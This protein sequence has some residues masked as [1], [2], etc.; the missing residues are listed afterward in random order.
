MG[1]LVRQIASDAKSVVQPP[2]AQSQRNV[3]ILAAAGIE[4]S[5]ALDGRAPERA[6]CSRDASHLVRQIGRL[7]ALRDADQVL[8]SLETGYQACIEITNDDVSCHGP[9]LRVVEWLKQMQERM[10]IEDDAIAIDIDDDVAR[11]PG[12]AQIARGGLA[13]SQLSAVR[14][15]DEPLFLKLAQLRRHLV[16]RSVADDDDLVR[17]SALF[18]EGAH[19]AF[20]RLRLVVADDHR[21]NVADV[22]IAWP[23][24]GRAKADR[25][26]GEKSQGVARKLEDNDEPEQFEKARMALR[27]QI[28]YAI[29]RRAATS[30][31]VLRAEG[32]KLSAEIDAHGALGALA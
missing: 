16:R 22:D 6:E 1:T 4:S 9:D 27:C 24:P 19:T 2:A 11:R 31:K 15:C 5:H 32:L 29:G 17:R 7:L 13:G 8:D 20:D 3:E 18:A 25:H 23:Y 14:L 21:G 10:P 28:D 12:E 26:D 30:G